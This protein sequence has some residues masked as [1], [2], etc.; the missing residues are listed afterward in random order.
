MNDGIKEIY[1]QLQ[2]ALKAYNAE[3]TACEEIARGNQGTVYKLT[4]NAE[5]FV[6]ALKIIHNKVLAEGEI[7]GIEFISE[8]VD[9]KL[10]KMY[11]HNTG[12]GVCYIAMQYLEGKNAH[13]IKPPLFKRKRKK[14]FANAVVDNLLKLQTV[15]ND[16][17][18]SIENAVYGNWNDFYKPFAARMLQFAKEQNAKGNVNGFV[19]STMEAAYQNYDKIFDEPVGEPV[20]THGDYWLSNITVNESMELTGVIDPFNVMWADREFDL[21]ALIADKGNKY[22]LLKTYKQKVRTTQK[23]DLKIAFY[24]AFTEIYWYFL[25]R[26]TYEHWLTFLAKKLKKQLKRFRLLG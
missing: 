12:G 9:I 16:K 15:T 21:L 25:T 5:P 26:K 14:A 7:K 10:P 24:Y 1:P 22:K 8:R 17:F 13:G 20:L 11:F 18:G 2:T 4:L 23:C 3:I 19:Y 6:M